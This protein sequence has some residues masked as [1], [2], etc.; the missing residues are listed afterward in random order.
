[1]FKLFKKQEKITIDLIDFSKDYIGTGQVGCYIIQ[2]LYDKLKFRHIGYKLE[3]RDGEMRFILY[4]LSG[5]KAPIIYFKDRCSGMI[6][7]KIQSMEGIPHNHIK[8]ENGF[9]EVSA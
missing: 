2:F 6:E 1:M 9:E 5:N 8:W 7:E 3:N 4:T